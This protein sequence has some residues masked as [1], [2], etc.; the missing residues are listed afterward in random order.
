MRRRTFITLVG[1]AA[2]WPGAARAQPAD[3]LRRI[4]VLLSATET[5]AEYPALLRA[6]VQE[7][8]VLGWFADRNVKIEVRWGEG[9]PQKTRALASELV[10]QGPDVIF[11]PG[12]ASMGP[13]HEANRNIPV[14]FTIVPDPVAAGFVES[15]SRP[16]GNATGFTSFEY[17]I[18]GKWLGLLK[19]VAPKLSITVAL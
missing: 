5:D 1:G 2:V 6:F 14:V 15:L 4:G 13:L 11:A 7:L 3:H 8:Q 12:G 17:G 10:T 9:N 18:G 16:G 19:E